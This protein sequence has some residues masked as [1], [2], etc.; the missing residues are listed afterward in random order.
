MIRIVYLKEICCM[1]S[2]YQIYLKLLLHSLCFYFNPDIFENFILKF[3]WLNLKTFDADN[4]LSV[5]YIM[6]LIKCITTDVAPN[7]VNLNT[8]K[9]SSLLGC[10]ITTTTKQLLMFQRTVVAPFSGW[11]SITWWMHYDASEHWKLFTSW[12]STT[13][14]VRFK[15]SAVLLWELNYDMNIISQG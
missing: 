4:I 7:H 15:Y 12:C 10:Y 6:S 2:K 14:S 13:S 9:D 5:L 8:I 3:I 1:N 11:S